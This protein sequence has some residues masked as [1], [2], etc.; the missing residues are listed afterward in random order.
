MFRSVMPRI[1]DPQRPPGSRVR[2]KSKRAFIRASSSS[3][4]CTDAAVR[5]RGERERVSKAQ[6]FYRG[7]GAA[8]WLG[9]GRGLGRLAGEG[10]ESCYAGQVAGRVLIGKFEQVSGRLLKGKEARSEVSAIF[11]ERGHVGDIVTQGGG[12][13]TRW[14]RPA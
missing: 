12:H 2:C 13:R 7:L 14:S 11:P 4:T 5:Y 9:K 1:R 8:D 6:R 3:P 10:W